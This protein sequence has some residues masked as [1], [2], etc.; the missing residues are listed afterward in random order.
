ML[1]ASLQ[2]S[3]WLVAAGKSDSLPVCDPT[4]NIL[5]FG[6]EYHT[7]VPQAGSVVVEITIELSGIVSA[8]RIVKSSN[9]RLN[10]QA[11]N[12]AEKWV[13]ESPVVAC[14]AQITVHYRMGDE[15]GA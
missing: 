7:R 9:P 8:A 4:P 2:P 12:A 14:R 6:N 13:F 11:L 15:H 3:V 10:E 5:S 1:L